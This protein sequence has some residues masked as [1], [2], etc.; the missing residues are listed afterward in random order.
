MKPESF[1]QVDHVIERNIVQRPSGKTP[2]KAPPVHA[3]CLFPMNN[4]PCFNDPP[5]LE[6]FVGPTLKRPL[7]AKS[8]AFWIKLFCAASLMF[9]QRFI[10]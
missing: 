6:L 5:R 1:Y 8:Q 9:S 3:C 10:C 2:E 4:L 7:F